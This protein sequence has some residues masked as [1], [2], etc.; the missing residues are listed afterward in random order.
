MERPY[1]VLVMTMWFINLKT[2]VISR[3]VEYLYYIGLTHRDLLTMRVNA[4]RPYIWHPY[5]KRRQVSFN[6]IKSH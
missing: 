3:P 2:A 1:K 5:L 4:I 6:Y